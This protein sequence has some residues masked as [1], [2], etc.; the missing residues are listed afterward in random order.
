MSRNVRLAA[1]LMSF[2]GAFLL[3]EAIGVWIHERR[4][5][6]QHFAVHMLGALL[7]GLV[8]WALLRGRRWAWLTVVTYG[9]LMGTAGLAALVAAAAAGVPPSALARAA[10][11]GLRLGA[12]GIPLGVFS[13]VTLVASVALLLTKQ[14]RADFPPSKQLPTLP[15]DLEAG[16]DQPAE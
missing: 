8:V 9:I 6:P 13:L 10:A 1:L 4:L 2:F 14:A 12:I 15:S 3:V 5:D 7:W 11:N 16:H